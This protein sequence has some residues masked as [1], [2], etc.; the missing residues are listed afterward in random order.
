MPGLDSLR[1]DSL[2]GRVER[3][4]NVMKD[5]Q[6][7]EVYSLM[8]QMEQE[9]D[10][11]AHAVDEVEEQYKSDYVKKIMRAQLTQIQ[12]LSESFQDIIGEGE[13]LSVTNID[14]N[15]S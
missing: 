13:S 8:D 14:D 15:N 2:A 4:T 6:L 12:E 9:V 7:E 11:L 10:I 3:T 1:F 5:N